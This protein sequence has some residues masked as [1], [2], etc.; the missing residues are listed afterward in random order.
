M[1]E[2]KINMP[3]KVLWQQNKSQDSFLTLNLILQNH[4]LGESALKSKP[5]SR[6]KTGTQEQAQ[7]QRSSPV[8]PV[9]T[10]L[11]IQCVQFLEIKNK[12]CDWGV[13]QLFRIK[14]RR[15]FN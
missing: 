10:Q 7:S 9:W 6:N 12:S 3:Q 5:A 11:V 13:K 8:L 14:Q 4:L 1:I 2:N 15:E